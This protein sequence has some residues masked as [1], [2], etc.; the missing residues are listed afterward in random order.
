MGLEPVD[1]AVRVD[2]VLRERAHDVLGVAADGRRARLGVAVH[3]EEGP[4]NAGA[5]G[6]DVHHH[7]PVDV[8]RLAREDRLSAVREETAARRLTVFSRCTWSAFEPD[9]LCVPS[10]SM[11][12]LA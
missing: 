8:G 12:G 1:E 2:A 4:V 11:V 3:A 7:P 10:R 9:V 6:V 5:V